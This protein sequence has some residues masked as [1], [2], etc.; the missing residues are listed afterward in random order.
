MPSAPTPAAQHADQHPVHTPSPHAAPPRLTGHEVRLW[1]QFLA[2]AEALH[3][4]RAAERLHMTQP[5]LTLAIQQLERHV[6]VPL[7]ARTRRSVAL[8]EAG[9]AL[10]EP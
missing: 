8:T 3:F 10:L 2:V 6:G 5:A 9:A 7:L 4:G 1:R